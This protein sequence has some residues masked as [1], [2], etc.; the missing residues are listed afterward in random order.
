MIVGCPPDRLLGPPADRAP[1]DHRLAL[2]ARLGTAA[3][4]H[5][6]AA[7]HDLTH[8]PPTPAD[9]RTHVES[10][11]QWRPVH[12]HSHQQDQ[13]IRTVA[14]AHGAT[15]AQVRIAWTLHQGPH[16]LAIPGT[17]NPDHVVENVAAG[18]LC[19]SLREVSLLDSAHAT[20][21]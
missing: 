8:P 15:P 5:A 1:T 21:E 13:L 10:R 6:R 17:G 3:R 7:G 14:R 19:L 20:S 11:P 12:D 16:V 18:A 4:R 9:R 2:A